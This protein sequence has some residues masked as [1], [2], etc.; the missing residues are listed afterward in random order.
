MEKGSA[1]A[2]E[3]TD[4]YRPTLIT[5]AAFAA[6]LFAIAAISNQQSSTAL[7]LFLTVLNGAATGASLNYT[8]VHLLHLTTEDTHFIVTS[9]LAM[10]RGF[11]GSFGSAIGGGIFQRVLRASLQR[12][13]DE[14]DPDPEQESELI[15]K[16]LG[17]PRL[18]LSLTGM[19]R[20]VAMASYEEAIT[21]VFV[22]GG[23]LALVAM[24]L[25]A[26]AGWQEPQPKGMD[27][28]EDEDEEERDGL[29]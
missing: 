9:V 15:R 10:F 17:N 20:R 27:A 8:L 14:R 29:V 13:F 1:R 6:A 28:D 25:Q 12:N 5:F 2:L 23:C 4:E 7:Y 18:V 19:Q 24:V 3:L 22:F 16:L 26:A 11:A 21:Y